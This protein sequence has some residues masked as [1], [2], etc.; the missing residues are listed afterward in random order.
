MTPAREPSENFVG[1]LRDFSIEINPND[2]K[3]VDN[4]LERL[5]GGTEVFLT[6]IPG[7]DP[8][9][10]VVA[11]AKLRLKGIVPVPHIGSRH[12]ESSMQLYD[13]ANRLHDTG[14][15]RVLIIG[16]DRAEPMGP[17][18]SSLAVMQSEILQRAGITQVAL[19]GFPEG[20]PNIPG[21]HLIE[22]LQTKIEFGQ[23]AGLQ[24]RIVTQFCFESEP[25]VKWLRLI[26]MRG[27]NVPV[28]IGFAGPA[29][30][31][32]LTRYAIRCGVGNS[33][34]VLTE[35]PAFAKLLVDEGPEPVIRGVY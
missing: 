10:M 18:D 15:D 30:L 25:I 11:G 1:A 5:A 19:A 12:I 23:S 33:I 29:G 32:A 9:K 8:S 21:N 27:I 14:I 4:A 20:N 6:W 24:L 2:S 31:L 28:R 34:R 13:L 3:T 22:T 17:Y 16:G 35:K 26:R 7:F